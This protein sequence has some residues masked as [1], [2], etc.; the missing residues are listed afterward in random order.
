MRGTD[1]PKVLKALSASLALADVQ[2]L[3]NIDVLSSF[4]ERPAA[5]AAVSA[6]RR[7]VAPFIQQK[8]LLDLPQIEDDME[9]VAARSAGAQVGEI[10]R[11]VLARVTC[12]KLGLG[13]AIIDGMRFAIENQFEYFELG[14]M[15]CLGVV[16]A[17]RTEDRRSPMR[18]GQYFST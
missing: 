1:E 9:S 11:T 8:E 6:P 14:V 12:C 7:L 3:A 5:A 17:R 2:Y 13:S 10:A 15:R 18:E 16:R 4:V